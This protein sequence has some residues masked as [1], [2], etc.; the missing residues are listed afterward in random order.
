MLCRKLEE[1]EQLSDG[2]LK[3][4]MSARRLRRERRV[5]ARK[6]GAAKDGPINYFPLRKRI[7]P[8]A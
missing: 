3:Q 4:I 6:K 5:A 7:W 2:G 1:E 8:P